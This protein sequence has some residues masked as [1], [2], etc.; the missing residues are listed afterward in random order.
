[1]A[2]VFPCECCICISVA[3]RVKVGGRTKKVPLWT[4]ELCQCSNARLAPAL[5]MAGRLDPV[6]LHIAAREGSCSG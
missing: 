3:E 2:F 6:P 5:L 4:S 1:V